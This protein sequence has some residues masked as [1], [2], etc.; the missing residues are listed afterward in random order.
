M[1]VVAVLIGL[2]AGFLIGLTGIGGGV[3]L[4]PLVV[5]VLGVAPLTA[6]GSNL[7]VGFFTKVGAGAMHHRQ[8][9]VDWSCV[10]WLAAGS[11]PASLVGFAVLHYLSSTNGHRVDNFIKLLAG[12][13]LLVMSLFLLRRDAAGRML[14]EAK[15]H[16][17]W[18]MVTIGAIAGF[19]VVTTS[20]GA[21][22]V[23]IM[24]LMWLYH[25]RA[26]AIVGTVIAHAVLLDGFT[27]LL[28][29]QLGS[30]DTRLVLSLLAGAIPGALL[31]ARL[32]ARIPSVPLRR[33]LCVGIFVAG[34]R[35]LWF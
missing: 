18:G 14:A 27:A 20:V 32:V 16:S 11:L 19:L 28:H 25:Q 9:T 22:S 24:L 12:V 6:V 3:V 7:A 31:G 17:R 34:V 4:F 29:L 21:G 13:V 26:Q 1:S 10:R 23:I 2:L 15:P 35:L 30:I 5:F 33:V 8:G